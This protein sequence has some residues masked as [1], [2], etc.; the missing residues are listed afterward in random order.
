M[1]SGVLRGAGAQRIAS[2]ISSVTLYI[3]A[4]PLSYFL[5][6]YVGYEVEGIWGGLTVAYCLQGSLLALAVLNLKV[7]EPC[8]LFFLFVSDTRTR[9]P[10][11]F[12]AAN[13]FR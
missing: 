11:S 4:L 2:V 10:P 5:G 3:V 1:L 12:F 7:Y 6:L 9:P 8:G 13:H